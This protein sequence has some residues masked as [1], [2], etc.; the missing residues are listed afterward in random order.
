MPYVAVGA[1]DRLDPHIES[2]PRSCGPRQRRRLRRRRRRLRQLRGDPPGTESRARH[3]L[4]DDRHRGWV[5]RN[6]ADEFYR[7]VG[8]PYEDENIAA[9]GDVYDIP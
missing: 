5:F 2:W 6:F 8:I 3:S 1:R 9:N 7:R 4:L